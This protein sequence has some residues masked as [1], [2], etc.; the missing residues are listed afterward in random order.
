MKKKMDQ[1]KKTEYVSKMIYK[2]FS[3]KKQE[4]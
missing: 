4:V 3:N 1:W 2:F